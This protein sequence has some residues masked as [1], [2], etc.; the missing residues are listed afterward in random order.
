MWSSST[1]DLPAA[2]TLTLSI[3]ALAE[4]AERFAR[5]ALAVKAAIRE[6]SDAV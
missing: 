4:L 3:S 5:A 6:F 2:A 1:S